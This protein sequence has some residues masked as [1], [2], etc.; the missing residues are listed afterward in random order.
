VDRTNVPARLYRHHIGAHVR[1][2]ALAR[3]HLHQSVDVM[4]GVAEESARPVIL[5]RATNYLHPA[6]CQRGTDRVAVVALAGSALELKLDRAIAI[7][8]LTG[9]VRHAAHA[10]ASP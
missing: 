1:H 10:H 6:R 5:E 9:D 3:A 4:V 7:D 8:Q 2:A